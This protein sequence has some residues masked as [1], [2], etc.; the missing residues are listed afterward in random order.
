MMRQ[1]KTL[2]TGA[3]GLAILTS[4]IFAYS[5]RSAKAGGALSS[6]PVRDVENGVR[7]RV[8][9]IGVVV[10]PNGIGG[11]EESVLTV[12]AGKRLVIDY[13][14]AR[15]RVQPNQRPKLSIIT[16]VATHGIDHF[17]P[18]TQLTLLPNALFDNVRMI[19]GEK[20]QIYADPGS[21]V[22]AFFQRD[23]EDG[24]HEGSGHCDV[25]ISGHFVTL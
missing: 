22:G 14:S 12:P 18:F 11:I 17:I 10:L 15:A 1:F 2:L 21:T 8:Q 4:V 9:S 16:S 19:A 23:S 25:I 7:D 20:V 6:T 24:L 5:I 13:V 3:V